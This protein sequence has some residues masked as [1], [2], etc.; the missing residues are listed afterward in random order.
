QNLVH[1]AS[2]EERENL[3]NRHLIQTR[4]A[5]AA[6]YLTNE[7]G[8]S[9]IAK[10]LTDADTAAA[11][12]DLRADPE[13]FDAERY[14]HIDPKTKILLDEQAVKRAEAEER[15]RV[16]EQEN[17]EKQ[18]EKKYKK[19]LEDNEFDLWQAFYDAKEAGNFEE[20][21]IKLENMAET[22][23]ID[24]SG[25]KA[26]QQAIEKASFEPTLEEEDEDN[27]PI[28]VG[29]IAEQLELGMDI[30]PQLKTALIEGDIK[31]ET[32]ISM[33]RA[34]GKA[35]YSQGFNFL[36]N[37]LKPTQMEKW[38][39]DRN[40]RYAEAIDEYNAQVAR[41]QDPLEVSHELVDLYLGDQRRTLGGLRRPRFLIGKKDNID[42]LHRAQEATRQKFL[43]RT[44]D[45]QEY[46][47]EMDL[48]EELMDLVDEQYKLGLEADQTGGTSNKEQRL[49]KERKRRE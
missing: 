12:A 15:R 38:N 39:P 16:R 8:I 27:D 13:S 41:G 26:L 42:D 29:Q 46:E 44:I 6:G 25:Y 49:I 22:R 18:A 45:A 31:T 33:L 1:G 43:N 32:Y 28:T 30:R 21:S 19:T 9:R 48:I 37:A 7:E 3:V 14:P 5:I 36:R 23:Q 10:F 34:V 11:M 35:D 2:E 17:A 40:L 20:L 24:K 4:G 47:R